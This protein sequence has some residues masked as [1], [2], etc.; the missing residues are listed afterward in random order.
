MATKNNGFAQPSDAA[1]N[2]G[3]SINTNFG[4]IDN[5]WQHKVTLGESASESHAM[6][7]KPAD[8]KAYKCIASATDTARYSGFLT[9]DGSTNDQ[10]YLRRYGTVSNTLWTLDRGQPAFIS[11]TDAGWLTP[12]EPTIGMMAGMAKTVTEIIIGAMSF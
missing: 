5:G 4:T 11:D 8:G 12:T 2:A 1:S 6:Y 7:I 10:R 9:E 3:N